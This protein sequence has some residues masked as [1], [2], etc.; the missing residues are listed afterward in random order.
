MPVSGREHDATEPGTVCIYTGG[1]SINGHVRI[2]AVTPTLQSV[3]LHVTDSVH[4]YVRHIHRLR[5]RSQGTV[6][7]LQIEIDI[8]TTYITPNKYTIFT[9]NQAAIQAIRNPKCPR[10]S[11]S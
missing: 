4:R 6:L 1:S 8:Q 5:S 9:D 11:I 3:H 10:D 2:A 7:A